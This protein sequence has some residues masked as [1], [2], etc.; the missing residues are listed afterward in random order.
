MD[1]AVTAVE[2]AFE[3]AGSGHY[4]TV[5]GIK[6]QLTAEGHSTAQIIGGTINKQLTALMRAGRE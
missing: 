3:L 6:K 5:A 2:R 4:T 1:R